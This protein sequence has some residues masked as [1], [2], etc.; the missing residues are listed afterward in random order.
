[1]APCKKLTRS[2]TESPRL[3]SKFC[4][5]GYMEC[6]KKHP[7]NKLLD[8]KNL[9]KSRSEDFTQ[10]V[11]NL[12]LL[13][14][15]TL[16]KTSSIHKNSNRPLHD[17]QR[18]RQV[19]TMASITWLQ[20]KVNQHLKMQTMQTIKVAAKNS[21]LI[22]KKWPIFRGSS[23]IRWTLWVKKINWQILRLKRS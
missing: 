23:P 8:L 18:K 12:I 22:R 21:P 2:T 14:T 15:I 1:M 9:A 11:V 17:R 7:A 5:Q 19:E 10:V 3:N 16:N 13:A 6:L 20:T 4:I